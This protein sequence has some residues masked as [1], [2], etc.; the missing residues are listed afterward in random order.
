MKTLPRAVSR[1]WTT[2]LVGLVA[3]L[4]KSGQA[5]G[6]YLIMVTLPT[7]YD[8]ATG[9]RYRNQTIPAKQGRAI[10][11]HSMG[12]FGAFH[13]A[14]DRPDLFSYVG[15][16]SGGLDLQD[17]SQRAAVVGSGLLPS[18]GTP[19]AAPDAIFGTPV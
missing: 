4:G 18:C 8:G 15:S 16:F 2:A 13:Y 10:A 9:T 17:P 7:G 14:E 1:G 19:L 12:G 5:S 3:M 6:E 11:G